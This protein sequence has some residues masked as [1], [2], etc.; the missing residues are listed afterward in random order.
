MQLIGIF[1]AK[2]GN[3]FSPAALEGAHEG[4][5]NREIAAMVTD[6]VAF[7]QQFTRVSACMN[8]TEPVDNCHDVA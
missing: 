7:R 1:C 8:I 3:R 4:G 6:T 2:F 5:F